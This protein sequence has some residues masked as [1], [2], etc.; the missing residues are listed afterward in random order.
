M[1]HGYSQQ[2][3]IFKKTKGLKSL[4]LSRTLYH[5]RQIN[6]WMDNAK[7]KDTLV[8]ENSKEL[9]I[10]WSLYHVIKLQQKPTTG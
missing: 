7:S 8:T 10:E 9:K 2:G 6:K 5:Y 1:I 3:M 4:S